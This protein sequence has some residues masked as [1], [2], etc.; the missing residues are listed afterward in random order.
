VANHMLAS[1]WDSFGEYLQ[2]FSRGHQSSL[3]LVVGAGIHRLREPRDAAELAALNTLASWDDFLTALGADRKN[4]GTPTLRWEWM[5]LDGE[6]SSDAAAK[7]DADHRAKAQRQLEDA[8]EKLLAAGADAWAPLPTVLRSPAVSDII[9]LNVD[10]TVER[11]IAESP[12]KAV[13]KPKP[14]DRGRTS[15]GQR[16]LSRHRL[17]EPAGEPARAGFR[18]VWH[19]HGDRTTRDSLV[20]GVWRYEQTLGPLSQARRDFKAA[21]RATNPDERTSQIS[22]EPRN[23]FELIMTR[24][25]LFLGTSLDAAEW[26]LWYALLCRWRNYRKAVHKE[27]L[28]PAWRLCIRSNGQHLPAD[29]IQRLEAD[30]WDQAWRFLA[31]SLGGV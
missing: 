27:Y 26:D 19:P 12:R 2:D 24:P 3:C 22:S 20:F 16:L 9:S 17:I 4:E 14:S 29:R 7:A 15:L 6:D 23:W 10:L 1:A 18:R 13:P 28:P 25:L 8:E 31:T 21:E 5:L 30:T 11:L